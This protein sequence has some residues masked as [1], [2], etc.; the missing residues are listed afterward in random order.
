MQSL[1]KKLPEIIDFAIVPENI[2]VIT[3]KWGQ[4]FKLIYV[5]ECLERH[6]TFLAT[7]LIF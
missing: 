7:K 2:K 4:F 3:G 6:F 5:E 1:R